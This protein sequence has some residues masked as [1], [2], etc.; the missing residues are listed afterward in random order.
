MDTTRDTTTDHV[1]YPSTDSPSN[2]AQFDTIHSNGPHTV[3]NP[4]GTV[5]FANIDLI[6]PQRVGQHKLYLKVDSGASANTIIVRTAK[7]IYGPR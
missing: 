5:A 3:V 6:C 1:H 4:Q 2:L 7:A